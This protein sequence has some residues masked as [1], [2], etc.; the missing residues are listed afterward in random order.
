MCG[1][2]SV[3]R[4]FI[5]CSVVP[6]HRTPEIHTTRSPVIRN[7]GFEELFREGELPIPVE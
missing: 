7:G 4:E 2:E 5:R 1:R 3:E 6:K